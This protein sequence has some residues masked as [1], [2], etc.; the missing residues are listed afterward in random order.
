MRRSRGSWKK[1]KDRLQSEFKDD[2]FLS[3]L[4]LQ[5]PDRGKACILL[6]SGSVVLKEQCD[7]VFWGDT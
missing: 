2:T 3:V 7:L 1:D 4:K 6:L 5:I